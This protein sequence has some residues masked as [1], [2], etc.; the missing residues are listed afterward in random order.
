MS[1][2]DSI[3]EEKKQRYLR[4]LQLGK[5]VW[6]CKYGRTIKICDMTDEHL[7]NTWR[8]LRAEGKVT[9]SEFDALWGATAN[10]EAASYY[11]EA[12]QMTAVVSHHLDWIEREAQFR[13]LKLTKVQEEPLGPA[14][15]I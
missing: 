3:P 6:L 8:T 12:A 15:E 10:G 1:W 7:L 4:L 2:L 14:K 9:E 5:K 11:L 13:N